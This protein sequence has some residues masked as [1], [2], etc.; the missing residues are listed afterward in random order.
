MRLRERSASTKGLGEKR[1]QRTLVHICRKI[2]GTMQD[3]DGKVFVKEWRA[4][5]IWRYPRAISQS[6][7]SVFSTKN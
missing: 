3:D 1:N 5:Y 4:I 2:T 7:V 6:M